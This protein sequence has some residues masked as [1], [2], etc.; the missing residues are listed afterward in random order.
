[1]MA[2]AQSLEADIKCGLTPNLQPIQ[3][4]LQKSMRRHF[5]LGMFQRY[6]SGSRLPEAVN[7]S[8]L[9]ADFVQTAKGFCAKTPCGILFHYLV[10]SAKL[11]TAPHRYTDTEAAISFECPSSAMH[12]MEHD[13]QW[14]LS[15]AIQPFPVDKWDTSN[16]AWID[17]VIGRLCSF[18]RPSYLTPIPRSLIHY[19]KNRN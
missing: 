16:V 10:L 11:E 1:M 13:L 9:V 6:A 4:Y 7:V 14:A 19:L 12:A 2:L 8:G 15:N 5:H 18:W 17:V 3:I